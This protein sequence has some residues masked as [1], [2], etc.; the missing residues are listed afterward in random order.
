M[1]A[2]SKVGKD[3]LLP[4]VR[5][6]IPYIHTYLSCLLTSFA[7][8]PASELP[9]FL[10]LLKCHDT[11]AVHAACIRTA[12]LKCHLAPWEEGGGGI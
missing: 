7:L 9:K 6:T 2:S 5:H 1:F 10:S 4:C 12:R 11:S 3:G 8:Y